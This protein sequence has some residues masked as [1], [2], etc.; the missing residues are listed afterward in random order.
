MI[1]L[2]SLLVPLAI[3]ASVVYFSLRN[4]ISPTPSSRKQTETLLGMIPADTTGNVYDLGSGLGTLA[5][6]IGK[7]LPQCQVIGFE[8]SPVPY[9]ISQILASLSAAKNVKFRRLDFMNASF[10][11]AK[12][13]LCYLYSGGMRKLKPKLET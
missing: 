1:I 13:I 10:C 4:G 9:V 8:S 12:V 2:G 7:Y 5:L 6:A 11:D 3:L